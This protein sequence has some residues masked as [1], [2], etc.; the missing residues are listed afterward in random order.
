MHHL[1]ASLS[2]AMSL[3]TASTG[4]VYDAFTSPP[5]S[6]VRSKR[7]PHTSPKSFPEAPKDAIVKPTSSPTFL[8]I[9]DRVAEHFLLQERA[10]RRIMSPTV[11]AEPRHRHRRP[12][13]LRGRVQHPWH[14]C[15]VSR[16]E[17]CNTH[18]HAPLHHTPRITIDPWLIGSLRL[19]DPDTHL[20]IMSP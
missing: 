3:H 13:K 19:C 18:I 12:I 7:R 6:S 14:H 1:A 4:L 17:N 9:S 16:V 20:L 10:Y 15:S 2:F 8:Q 5:S 11:A